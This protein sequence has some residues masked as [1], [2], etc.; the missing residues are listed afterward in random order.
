[1]CSE[2]KAS[3]R[4]G[5][6]F[7]LHET[8]SVLLM[9]QRHDSSEFVRRFIIIFND[10]FFLFGTLLLIIQRLFHSYL[11]PLFQWTIYRGHHVI[12][13]PGIFLIGMWFYRIFKDESEKRKHLIIWTLFLICI[14]IWSRTDIE[15]IKAAIAVL[16]PL[17]VGF[18]LYGILGNHHKNH[19]ESVP[20]GKT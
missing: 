7:R 9:S 12:E 18:S 4:Q 10:P 14:L 5:M 16:W 19:E 3:L 13:L 20:S 1:M 6:N 8:T 15:K 17:P 11:D 2:E